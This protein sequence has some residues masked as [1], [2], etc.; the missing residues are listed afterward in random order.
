MYESLESKLSNGFGTTNFKSSGER[1]IADFLSR[2]SIAYNYEPG[3]VVYPAKAQPR[4]WYPD[5]YLPD[6][7]IYIEY[8]GMKGNAHYNQGM[9][10]KEEVYNRQKLPV[11]PMYPWMF[12]EDWQG[13]L[14][15][16]VKRITGNRYDLGRKLSS[17]FFSNRYHPP[18]SSKK[19][20]GFY[21]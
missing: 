18:N 13:Y 3:I 17:G 4:I 19:G 15:R 9:K 21:R 8:F 20:Y 7:G 16:E 11:I 10:L 1:K 6:L 14:F 5:F 12:G 2:Y